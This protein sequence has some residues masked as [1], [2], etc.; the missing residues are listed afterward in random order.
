[1][2][3]VILFV[4]FGLVF[5]LSMRWLLRYT[6]QTVGEASPLTTCVTYEYGTDD[7]WRWRQT[8]TLVLIVLLLSFLC[9]MVLTHAPTATRLLHYGLIMG[10]FVLYGVYWILLLTLWRVEQRLAALV[11]HTYV[12]LDPPTQSLTLWRNDVP[13]V[14][15]KDNVAVIEHHELIQ[16]RLGYWFYRFIDQN[17]NNVFFYDYGRGLS[18]GIDAYF[19]GT[20]TRFV[21]HRYP[22]KSVSIT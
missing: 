17:G 4:S 10:M 19:K 2:D 11:R 5:A 15:T 8:P 20:P 3:A 7:F 12:V 14:L 13:T 1:M 22:F 16:G 18:F 21:A 9:G 6:A